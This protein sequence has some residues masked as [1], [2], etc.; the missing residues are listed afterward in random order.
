MSTFTGKIL[1]VDD[2][3]DLCLSM[4]DS[5]EEL[6][7]EVT[8]ACSHADALDILKKDSFSLVLTD[9]VM[10]TKDSGLNLCKDVR[11][12]HPNLPVIILTGFPSFVAAAVAASAGAYDFL[13]KPFDIQ[14]LAGLISAI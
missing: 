4:R 7:F 2:D 8:V 3:E 5:L 1:F 12:V 9:L 13:T 6:G 14:E 10:E 11:V